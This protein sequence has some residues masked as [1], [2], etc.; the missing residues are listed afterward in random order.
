MAKPSLKCKVCGAHMEADT[1]E[2]LV[3]VYQKHAK[4]AHDMDL[5]EEMA[6]K[7]VKE[8]QFGWM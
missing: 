7:E 2:E 3:K 1:E 4:K 5:S 8:S 6:A